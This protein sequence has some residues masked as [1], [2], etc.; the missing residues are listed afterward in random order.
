MILKLSRLVTTYF[1]SPGRVFISC[2]A[3]AF[4]WLIGDGTLIHLWGT[5]KNADRLGQRIASYK[6]EIK[7]LEE[8]LELSNQPDFVEKKARD[9]FDLVGKDEIIFVFPDN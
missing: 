4:V 8:Q 3:L 1:N 7:S 9:R 6:A 2:L 5:H